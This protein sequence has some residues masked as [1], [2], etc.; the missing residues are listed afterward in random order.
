MA[1]T[2][3]AL[4]LDSI[5]VRQLDGLFCLNDLHAAA[6]SNPKDRPPNFLRRQETKALI[7]ELG[8]CS[9][10]STP[11]R[12]ITDGENNGTYACR[13]LV[14]AYAAWISAAFHLKVIRVFLEVT[15]TQA[16]A[17][18]STITPAQRQELH[19]LV[20]L[21]V[22]SGK[23]TWGETWKR[24]HNK[25]RVA[26]YEQLPAA[27][28]EEAK[29]YLKGKLDADSVATLLG[30]HVNDRMP[31]AVE[32]ALTAASGVFT[33]T[34]RHVL[35]HQDPPS[36]IRLLAAA[37]YVPGQGMKPSVTPI[38]RDAY[39]MTDAE[40]FDHLKERMGHRLAA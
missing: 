33:E 19:E 25:F 35:T 18:P 26:K 11:L 40:W 13:E 21:I 32:M 20:Q 7:A 1:N 39:V 5:A 14:I 8:A 17:L 24:F 38:S 37:H 16:P 9:N 4:I 28:F 29:Q 27:R 23:Q 36:V 34:L 10:L 22:E 12:T 3:P 30:K 31:A 15:A 6:G 2:S